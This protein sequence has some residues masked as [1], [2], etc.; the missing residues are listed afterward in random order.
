MIVRPM[1]PQVRPQ[2]DAV[3][4]AGN[5][6][7]CAQ[8]PRLVQSLRAERRQRKLAQIDESIRL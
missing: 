1:S 8:R 3:E 6:Q 5:A 2:M 7:K 4:H